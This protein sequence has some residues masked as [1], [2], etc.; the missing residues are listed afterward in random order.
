MGLRAGDY[1]VELVLDD[2]LAL[3]F[4]FGTGLRF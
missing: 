2:F 3:D 4:Y 1:V